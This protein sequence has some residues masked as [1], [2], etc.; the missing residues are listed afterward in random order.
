MQ[1]LLC[2]TVY[3]DD[4]TI[5]AGADLA[6]EQV[7]VYKLT[8]GEYELFE[9]IKHDVG[10]PSNLVISGNGKAVLIIN[11]SYRGVGIISVYKQ[12]GTRYSLADNIYNNKANL[13]DDFGFA[14]SNYI[15][16]TSD[17]Q[18]EFSLIDGKLICKVDYNYDGIYS[19]NEKSIYSRQ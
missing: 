9:I 3:S 7:Y 1:T 17:H 16:T 2:Y 18:V 11:G 8:N 5:K 6:L 19:E 12:R 10:V 4:K 15:L 13:D 14:A